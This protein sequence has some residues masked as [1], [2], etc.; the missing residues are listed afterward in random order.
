MYIISNYAYSLME[1]LLFF[2]NSF[3]LRANVCTITNNAF[4]LFLGQCSIKWSITRVTQL[5][6]KLLGYKQCSPGSYIEIEQKKLLKNQR[7]TP[8]P[9]SAREERRRNFL[10]LSIIAYLRQFAWFDSKG[11]E[12]YGT[13]FKRHCALS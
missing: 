2:I 3:D 4:L 11:A 13:A 12:C 9:I 10:S 7:I 5:S 1:I 6:P 8:S